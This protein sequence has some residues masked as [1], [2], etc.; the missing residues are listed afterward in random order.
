MN[1]P[2]VDSGYLS[3]LVR[4]N[5]MRAQRSTPVSESGILVVSR[6]LRSTAQSGASGRPASASP[7]ETNGRDFGIEASEMP[8]YPPAPQGI[9]EAKHAAVDTPRP[10]SE[11][12]ARDEPQQNSRP[13]LATSQENAHRYAVHSR[14]SVSD[15]RR[16]MENTVR[17]AKA[18]CAQCPF[19]DERSQC[20]KPFIRCGDR[21]QYSMRETSKQRA[22]LHNCM[23]DPE[24]RGDTV[25]I[26]DSNEN[27]QEF[28]RS[29]FALFFDY[30]VE[31]IITTGSAG[32]A[33]DYLGESKVRE[34]R[35][36]L[37]ISDINLPGTS[38]YELVNE[39]YYRN[40]YID[41][42]LMS[43]KGR[44]VS[45]PPGYMGEEEIVPGISMVKG[46][47]TK[48]FHSETLTKMLQSIGFGK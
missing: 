3:N 48:P 15:S 37:L 43:D 16:R 27:M 31:K 36:G 34:N 44:T 14:M 29:S 4:S 45:P 5:N 33:L 7:A 21:L 9:G 23:Y 11:P 26:V 47:I 35:I 22:G 30:P 39:L 40:F 24:N 18:L 10:S 32:Q 46:Y 20:T 1:V 8:H 41:V 42:I 17:R 2:A 19:R 28:C 13:H 6:I 12:P 38:G 25:L